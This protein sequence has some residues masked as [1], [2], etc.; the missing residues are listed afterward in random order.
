MCVLFLFCFVLVCFGLVVVA[1][2]VRKGGDG[3]GFLVRGFRWVRGCASFR[4]RP[5]SR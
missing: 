1:V 3:A 5:V 4:V 2:A